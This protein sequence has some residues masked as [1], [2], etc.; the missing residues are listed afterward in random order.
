MKLVNK[1]IIFLIFSLATIT[2]LYAANLTSDTSI[3][4]TVFNS[5]LVIY[6]TS[7][8]AGAIGSL[9]WNGV[10]FINSSDHGRE[11]QSASSFDGL[12]ECFNPTEAGSL[13]DG[14]GA[15]STSHL[16]GISS[17]F[18]QLKTTSL[19]AFWTP[20]GYPYPNGCGTKR[21]LKIAQNLTNL[22]NHTL[23]KQ[24]TIGFSGISNVI[25]YLVTFRVPESHNSATFEAV[26]GYMPSYF[27]SF[28]TFNPA[29]KQLLPLTHVNG[30]QNIPI[31][32]S[33][34]DKKYAMGINWTSN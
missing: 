2:S 30:E 25:E 17:S 7:R 4:A 34:S 21:N 13:K 16:L 20:A 23:S 19:M 10:E 8:L 26:T 3:Q 29:T 12:G 6:T 31:I 1:K 32:L 22:S 18:N 24:V 27:S 5:P 33:S 9:T 15:K 11:L 28:W 14:A